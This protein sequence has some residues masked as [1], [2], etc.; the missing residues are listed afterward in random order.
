MKRSTR[1]G[2]RK[3]AALTAAC[4]LFASGCSDGGSSGGGD[5]S[6]GDATTLTVYSGRNVELI[7]PLVEIFEKES[8]I[9][10]E[11]RGG[12]TPELAAQILTEGDNS[13]ADIFFAQDA[14]ALGAVAKTGQFEKLPA[15][16]IDLVPDTYRAADST[17]VG[18]SGRSRVIVYNPDL[19]P[20]PPTEIDGLLDPQWKGQLGFAPTNASWHSFVTALRLLRGED[21]ARDWLERF[22]ANEP[23]AY[24]NN[25][26]VRDAVDAGDIAMGPI[27]HYYLYELI[28]EVG[29]DKVTAKNQFLSGGDPG[30]LVNVAG[31]GILASAPHR[32]AA[33]EFVRFLLGAEAQ[34]YF[35]TATFEY[36]LVAGVDPP[37]GVPSLDSLEPPE[38]DLADLDSLEET[39]DLLAEVGLLTR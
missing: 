38:I 21:G 20:D 28:D 33:L 32:D 35:A 13:P 23:Q 2:L 30:G 10:V 27:N 18:T 5:Q 1:Q 39:L 34:E 9:D 29:A 26:V 12:G 17:W 24:E 6:D 11:L 4:T 25:A 22:I 14:G 15:D 16:I 37:E 7:E 3:L 31:V 19:V 36:P 8:G